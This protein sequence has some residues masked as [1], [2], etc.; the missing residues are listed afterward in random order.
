MRT[1][2]AKLSAV[3]LLAVAFS[4]LVSAFRAN[5]KAGVV[6][7][8][9]FVWNGRTRTYALFVPSSHSTELRAVLV[10]HHGTGGSGAEMVQAW[11]SLAEEEGF[12][13]VAPDGK[14][15]F[16]WS[17][18]DDGP[19]LQQQIVESLQA[20]YR[21]DP[22]RVYLF[23]FSAGGDFVFYAALQQSTYFA[24]ACIH[25]ASLRPR[26]FAMLDLAER[27]I[28]IFYSVGVE[29]PIYPP[30][31]ARATRRAFEQR[32]WPLKT[33][34]YLTG[35]SY[36]PEDVNPVCWNYLKKQSLPT[37]SQ[38]TPLSQAWLGYALY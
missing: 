25:E 3:F 5:P 33:I 8:R 23:G 4:A 11:R 26:Q 35:H 12:I 30:A 13:L 17:V 16:G 2:P 28:P 32:K 20:E 9:K 15:K 37:A 6:E 22:R 34:E 14:G 29:D 31:E 19:G 21:V 36:S 24:A 1:L 38:R 27:K 7:T 10:L 18:P